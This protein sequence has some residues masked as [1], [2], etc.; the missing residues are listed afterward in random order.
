MHKTPR[1]PYASPS[2]SP[3]RS[4]KSPRNKR[5]CMARPSIWT[6]AKHRVGLERPHFRTRLRGQ[7]ESWVAP[8][9]QETSL[10]AR[11]ENLGETGAEGKDYTVHLRLHRFLHP[12]ERAISLR[13]VACR[14]QYN[15]KSPWKKNQNGRE[16]PHFFGFQPPKD[17][18]DRSR[19]PRAAQGRVLAACRSR[20]MQDATQD[21]RQSQRRGDERQH[22]NH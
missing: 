7:S 18:W 5:L 1:S 12:V 13:R 20:R 14:R 3:W 11:R 17:S 15:Q 22:G 9:Q 2:R 6:R 4:S 16:R 10:G 8:A 19:P 21:V